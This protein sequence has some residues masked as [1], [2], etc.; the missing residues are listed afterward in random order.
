MIKVNITTL[1]STREDIHHRL[2]GLSSESLRNLQS[3]SPDPLPPELVDI[4]YWPA[5]DGPVDF[6]PIT[7]YASGETL[8]AD[9]ATKTVFV[10]TIISAL[11]AEEVATNVA[12]YEAEMVKLYGDAVQA[13][14]DAECVRHTYDGIL[15]LCTY[16]GS[17][18]SRF[19]LEGTAGVAWRDACWTYTYQVLA[20]VKAATRT[21]PTAEEL[22]AELPAIVWP[23]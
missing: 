22:L 6:N 10:E 5:V 4:E 12:A 18:S 1:E 9:A 8:T 20:D 2:K 14:M 21:Q 15:S 7:H 23:V 11:S 16:A 3:I 19:N 17:P 13:H